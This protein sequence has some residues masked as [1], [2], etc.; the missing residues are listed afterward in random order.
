MMKGE[1]KRAGTAADRVIAGEDGSMAA[2]ARVFAGGG[3]IWIAL[4][5]RLTGDDGATSLLLLWWCKGDGARVTA[6]SG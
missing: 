3:R 2:D 4:L 1:A 6:A 5:D